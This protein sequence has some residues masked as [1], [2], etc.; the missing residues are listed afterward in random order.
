MSH[1]AV[2]A[3]SPE[4]RKRHGAPATP[5]PLVSFV[6]RSVHLLLQ[7][8]FG[9]Q[10][11]LADRSVRVLDPAAGDL[12]FVIEAWRA[13]LDHLRNTGQ[14]SGLDRLISSHLL[15]HFHGVERRP[16]AC[17]KGRRA[18]RR[19]FAQQGF[20]L[21]PGQVASL[22]TADALAA[23]QVDLAGGIPVLLGHPPW[24]GSATRRETWICDLLH[25]YARPDGS[26]EEGYFHVD[27]EPL[28]ERTVKGLQDDSVKLLRLAQWTIDQ[29]GNGIVAL[30]VPHGCLNAPAFKGLRQ[31]L[32]RTF[33]EIYALDLHGNRRKGEPAPDGRRDDNVLSGVSQGTAVLFLVK[34]GGFRRRVFLADLYGSR[35]EKLASL[36]SSDLAAMHWKELP[37]S[38]PCAFRGR[39]GREDQPAREV[40]VDRAPPNSLRVVKEL[41]RSGS[42]HRTGLG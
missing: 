20:P 39:C 18:A 34:N 16:K 2:S 28:A 5:R 38:V 1:R 13:A 15:P 26:W 42:V 6:V 31:S 21:D 37:T 30:A 27:G 33:N 41:T 25:G 12:R 23:P 24:S 9:L 29:H 10:N 32:V 17:A 36:E 7:S 3:L 14:E 11:G 35:R 40:K 4:R 8:R 22:R 19:F